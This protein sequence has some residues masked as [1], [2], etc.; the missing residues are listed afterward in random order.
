[1]HVNR[2]RERTSVGRNAL[3]LADT[4]PKLLSTAGRRCAAALWKPPA[5]DQLSTLENSSVSGN[6]RFE[7]GLRSTFWKPAMRR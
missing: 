7:K 4:V 3:P 6:P 1:M 5:W 2:T